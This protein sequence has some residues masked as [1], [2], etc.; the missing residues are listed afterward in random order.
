MRSISLKRKVHPGRDEIAY[1]QDG[2][3]ELVEIKQYLEGGI[4]PKESKVEGWL[5]RFQVENGV[6]Y[7]GLL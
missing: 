2:D 1:M 3:E 6:L 5:D 4:L 7:H